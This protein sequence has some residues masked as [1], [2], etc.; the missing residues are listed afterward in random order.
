MKGT[1]FL[2][3]LGSIAIVLVSA[4]SMSG[5][6]AAAPDGYP[7]FEDGR[8]WIFG[9]GTAKVRTYD[10]VEAR[11]KTKGI[12]IP[13]QIPQV[14]D[15]PHKPPVHGRSQRSGAGSAPGREAGQIWNKDI[16][17]H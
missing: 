11:V 7:E 5:N 10:G 3:R 1:D 2:K 15:H 13:S 12:A 9:D 17:S 8:V 4:L 6:A 14:Q 16:G